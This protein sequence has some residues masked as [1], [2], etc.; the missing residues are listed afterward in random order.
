MTAG[1]L[2][3]CFALLS[4]PHDAQPQYDQHDPTT[5][6]QEPAFQAVANDQ[7]KTKEQDAA[8]MET[9]FSAHENTPMVS[10]FT[11]TKEVSPHFCSFPIK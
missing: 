6:A 1:S 2:K 9:I 7:S 8:A 10:L 4:L 11:P 3:Y 5:A